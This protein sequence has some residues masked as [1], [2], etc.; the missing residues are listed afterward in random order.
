MSEFELHSADIDDL[1]SWNPDA[2]SV[3]EAN[4]QVFVHGESFQ[5]QLCSLPWLMER[6]AAS[7]CVLLG[8]T[9]IVRNYSYER[10]IRAI[11][12]AMDEARD[13]D[14][15][16]FARSLNWYMQWES[17]NFLEHPG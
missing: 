2:S 7:E 12:H 17:E 16:N 15:M 10:L 9:A 14:W 13:P 8:R 11:E 6:L 1:T 5:F 4:I 3:W